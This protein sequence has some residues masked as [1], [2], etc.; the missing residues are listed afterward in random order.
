M[1][2]DRGL[3]LSLSRLHYWL[4]RAQTHPDVVQGTAECHHQSADAFFPEA[5][6][7]F[8]NA[9]TLDPAVDMLDPQPTLV[10]G[11]V[12]PLLFQGEFTTW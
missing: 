8:D 2:A 11:L 6:A 12:G 5:E 3:Y 10:Q 1:L 9:T 7:V 4:P